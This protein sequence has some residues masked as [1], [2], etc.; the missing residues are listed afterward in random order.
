MP[1]V[2]W[3][4]QGTKQLDGQTFSPRDQGAEETWPQ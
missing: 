2:A 4:V 3:P 1:A